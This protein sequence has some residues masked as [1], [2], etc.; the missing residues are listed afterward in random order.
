VRSSFSGAL[1][2]N[3]RSL[4]QLRAYGTYE[5]DDGEE[6]ITYSVSSSIPALTGNSTSHVRAR[7]RHLRIG[8]SSGRMANLK[9]RPIPAC[10]AS[11]G[12]SDLP[13]L[14][15]SHLL[16]QEL[17]VG[18]RLERLTR[19]FAH[20]AW[21]RPNYPHADRPRAWPPSG[22]PFGIASWRFSPSTPRRCA[23][24]LGVQRLH[25]RTSDGGSSSGAA[26]PA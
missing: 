1:S 12:F 9:A 24:G 16:H 19:S 15:V 23:A 7:R 11:S 8:H 10:L 21:G 4:R 3:G 25:L 13:S 2:T 18:Q 14:S 20:T 17:K 26:P 22:P 5:V 6:Q